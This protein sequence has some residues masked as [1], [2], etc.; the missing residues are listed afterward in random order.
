M[1]KKYLRVLALE[2]PN[3]LSFVFLKKD[4]NRTISVYYLLDFWYV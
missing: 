3:L 1:G 2:P 4:I